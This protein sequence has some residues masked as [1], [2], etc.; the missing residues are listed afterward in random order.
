MDG[1]WGKGN[2]FENDDNYSVANEIC[3]RSKNIEYIIP[4]IET[5]LI[6]KTRLMF[7]KLICYKE[8]AVV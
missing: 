5:K 2:I 8:V 1:D 7:L 6:S 3:F 4:R